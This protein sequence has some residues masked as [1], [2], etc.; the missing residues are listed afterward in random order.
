MIMGMFW[1]VLLDHEDLSQ[2]SY[3]CHF[4]LSLR[5]Q[6]EKNKNFIFLR[7]NIYLPFMMRFCTENP[8]SK[9]F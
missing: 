1:K 4:I 8:Y 5:N 7:E 3:L 6:N 2:V 9:Y